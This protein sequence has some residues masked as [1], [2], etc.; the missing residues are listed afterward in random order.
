MSSSTVCKIAGG[1]VKRNNR[2]ATYKQ[3]LLRH[4]A[5]LT[6]LK[7]WRIEPLFA[8][9]IFIANVNGD[10]DDDLVPRKCIVVDD[11]IKYL[12]NK[13]HG[14]Y[15]KI[16]YHPI[17]RGSDTDIDVAFDEETL[18]FDDGIKV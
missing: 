16:N 1:A 2:L 4:I 14:K 7:E 6:T 3:Q 18:T 5:K 12:C 13:Y 15:V 17:V 11:D 8:K 10:L 9:W